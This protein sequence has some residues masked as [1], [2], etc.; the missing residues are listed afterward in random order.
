VRLPELA[1][2][3]IPLAQSVRIFVFGNVLADR[4]E[5]R[6]HVRQCVL[7]EIDEHGIRG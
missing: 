2:A 7:I 1:H 3:I 4:V 6:R 5:S